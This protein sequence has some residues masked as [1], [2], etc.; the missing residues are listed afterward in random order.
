VLISVWLYSAWSTRG[1]LAETRG[2]DLRDLE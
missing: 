2:G 1:A